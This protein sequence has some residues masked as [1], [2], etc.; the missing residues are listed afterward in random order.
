LELKVKKR[1]WLIGLSA[2][3][4]LTLTPL[5]AQ[6]GTRP[7]GTPPLIMPVAGD[8][9]P[10]T[11]LMGQPH[12]NTVGSFNFGQAWYSAGQGMHFGIDISM[13]CGTPLVAVADGE[14]AWV[15]NGSF[16]SAPHNLILIHAQHN[17]TTLYGHLL[18]PAPLMQGQSVTQGQLVGYSGDPDLTCVSRP[19]LHFEVRSMNYRTAYN[20]AVWINANWNTLTTIGSFQYPMFQQDLNNP[21]RWMSLDDQPDI[22]FGGARL[23]DYWLTSPPPTNERPPMSPPL[24]LALEPLPADTTWTL[25]PLN[26]DGCCAAPRWHPTDPERLYIVDGTPAVV[27]EWDAQ[28]NPLS[29][30]EAAPAP[31]TSPDGT[32]RI[33]NPGW[34]VTL[35]DAAGNSWN[36]VT[37]RTIPSASAPITPVCFGSSAQAILSPVQRIRTLRCG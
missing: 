19:H 8:P 2:L 23:N 33:T 26:A 34:D 13:P 6:D 15:D 3:L 36:V 31:P 37:Q 25:R 35:T 17:V 21:R 16:G 18:E 1:G 22:A 7:V 20:P 12:G 24:P 29:V 14:V 10:G 30:V 5:H 27:M 9:G 4:L 28:G 11:W 32:I